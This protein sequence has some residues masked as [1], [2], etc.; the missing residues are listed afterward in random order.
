VVLREP[1]GDRQLLQ[2]VSCAI[3]A[4]A[5]VALVGAD[6]QEKH[7]LVCLIP[8]F[9]DPTSGEIRG[10]DHNLRWV[11]LES[12]RKQVGLVLR[13]SLVFS[14]TVNRNIGC[15]DDRIKPG[16]IVEAAKLAHAHQ[17]IQ[18]LPQGYETPIGE[19]GQA[20]TVSEQFRIALARAVLLNPT[21][22]IIEEPP[23]SSLSDDE[24]YLLDDTFARALPGKTVLFLAHRLATIRNCNQVFLLHKGKL[25]A[26][27]EHRDLIKNNE[28]YQYLMYTE[29]SAFAR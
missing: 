14:D 29:F 9:L 22:F 11:S 10:D 20:L 15:G 16:Q 19:S 24:Q 6:E 13:S 27:G 8:R 28:L 23:Q 2:G 25:E 4:G 1:G 26:R 3:P 21:L 17:F 18:K 5:K 12:L 7:A